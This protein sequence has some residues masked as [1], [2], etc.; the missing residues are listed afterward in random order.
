MKLHLPLKYQVSTSIIAVLSLMLTSTS[1]LA[2]PYGP[3]QCLPGFVWREAYS[4]DKVCVTP[5]VRTQAAADNAQ[6]QARKVPNG[7]YGPDTCMQGFVWRETV[8]SDHVCVTGSVRAQ[9]ATDDA[10]ALARRDPAC[11]AANT[12]NS[13]PIQIGVGVSDITGPIAEV[14]MMGYANL[15]QKT[16]GLYT[17]LYARAFV[18]ANPNSRKRVV[19]VTAELGQLFSSVKQGVMKR[20]RQYSPLYDDSNVMI[21]ATHTHSGPGGYSHYAMY[22]FTVLGFVP[23]NYDVIVEGI[24]QA[25]VQADMNVGPATLK[26]ASNTLLDTNTLNTVSV[27][28]SLVA[29]NRNP[30]AQVE[31]FKV[32]NEMLLL[33]VDRP[34]G[35]AGSIAWYSSH[36]TSLSQ[37][38]HL[39]GS[40]HAGYAAYLFERAMGNTTQQRQPGSFIAAFANSDEGD[41]SPN[42]GPNFTRPGN[43]D[44]DAVRIIGEREF[45]NAQDL[46][47]NH[48]T[49]TVT[50]PLD[51]RHLFVKMSGLEIVTDSTYVNGA[52]TR[53][54]CEGAFGASFAAGSTEDGP[55]GLPVFTEGMT[56]GLTQQ[57]SNALAGVAMSE[58]GVLGLAGSVV[59]P[60]GTAVG[61]V[62]MTLG[63]APDVAMHNCQLPKPVLIASGH[64]GWTPDILPFQ[65]LR[66]GTLAIAAVPSEMTTQ[67]GRRLRK[68]IL[69]ALGPS[70]VT[71]VVI[72]GLANEYSGYVTTPEEYDSQQYEGASTLYGRLTFEAYRMEFGKLADAMAH[73][74]SLPNFP[75]QPTQPDMSANQISLQ[76]GVVYDDKRLFETFGQVFN[77][78]PASVRPGGTVT[79]TFR[80]GHPKNDLKTN[81]TYLLVEQ[82][83][84]ANQWKAVAWDSMPE[85][86]LIWTRDTALD[87]LACSFADVR[88]DVPLNATP[89]TY[90]I[91]HFGAWKDGGNGVIKP[92]SG[93]TNTF[94]VSATGIPGSVCGG[95]GQRACCIGEGVA[96]KP[97]LQEVPGCA[98]AS[99]MCGGSIVQAISHCVA[100]PPASPCGG[101]GQRACCIGEGVACKPGLQEVPGCAGASCMCGGSIVQAISHCVAPPPASPCGGAGQR[102]CCI[103][104]GVAC[105]PGL[106]EVPGCAGA[107]CTCGGS[108]VQAISHC[109]APPPVS[110]CGGAGQRAC[111][112]GEGTACK[113]GLLEIPGCTG[114][115][116]S[117]GGSS[118]PAISH[119]IATPSPPSTAACGDEGQRACCLGE[120]AG[121]ACNQGL[122][123]VPGCTGNNC[124]CGGWNPLGTSSSGICVR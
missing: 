1:V 118:V 110:P 56:Q 37:N 70:G 60:V 97:G 39:V 116:C 66:V 64:F 25:I 92:Y 123:Q 109:V 89:G 51:Y 49:E 72:T 108:I 78:P 5:D 101:A 81:S 24:Y 82:Q 7:P 42:I 117:C 26:L 61:G 71:H 65:L 67:A 35:P 122:T 27:N 8:P 6:A 84:A 40:D 121:G 124:K 91:R 20:L 44:Y 111:C 30:E 15:G 79:A 115:N 75:P 10:Q 95:A 21:S 100:P 57:Q 47:L 2:C 112:I 69:T 33:R 74:Q 102:A 62:L 54:L 45:A 77:Q 14:G 76:T 63:N 48:A 11:S 68:R 28:R 73:G 120:R 103:G 17:R 52:G 104:E 13:E 105:K 18:F 23:Q 107:S 96:C 29:Y 3:E 94:V 9:A 38:N 4:G 86:R 16:G 41:V 55:S 83:I 46:F 31:R 114:A 58:L 99:C 34:T 36:N 113:P 59:A 93:T 85:T 80:A 22:N 87:C 12:T 98:G 50:G 119:C 19:L 32:N 106:Q 88:W 43:D 53:V 90:R